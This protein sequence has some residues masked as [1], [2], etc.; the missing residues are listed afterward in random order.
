MQ[1]PTI[2]APRTPFVTSRPPAAGSV[3]RSYPSTVADTG[4][5]GPPRAANTGRLK[6]A[7]AGGLLAL[8]TAGA[9]TVAA[10]AA[11]ALATSVASAPATVA[12][13]TTVAS[14]AASVGA[15]A[16]SARGQSG[17]VSHA[18]K[19][20]RVDFFNETGAPIRIG[21]RVVAPNGWMYLEGK[22]GEGDD[23]SSSITDSTGQQV[24]FY[25]HNPFWKE[26]YLQFD[27]QKVFRSC[28]TQAGGM[29]F[30]VT[31]IGGDI[32]VSKPW[33]VHV[34]QEGRFA[35]E[36]VHHTDE[37]D[38]VKGTVTN[39]SSV[40]ATV[41][42]GGSDLTLR[43]GQMLL[44]FDS[45]DF[46]SS[47]GRGTDMRI[48][49]NGHPGYELRAGDRSFDYP[50]VQMHGCGQKDRYSFSE[51]E[52]RSYHWGKGLKLDVTREDDGK[53]DV[54]YENRYTSDWARFNIVISNG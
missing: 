48:S 38:G 53:M 23:I 41:R 35:H 33:R 28:Y 39:R 14:T 25:G 50:L 42:L 19:G 49:G 46:G 45:H 32:T 8:L 51:G 34:Y 1:F 6:R 15:P 10:P 3:G 54:P 43:P 36:F 26:A 30:K 40:E 22:S 18:T 31:F 29:G 27:G 44:F 2:P 13:A 47:D 7:L 4:A 20:T 11:P 9:A 24:K 16:M 5:H 52:S 12:P 37:H 17:A 21:D